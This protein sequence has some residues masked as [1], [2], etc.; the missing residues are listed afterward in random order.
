MEKQP[1]MQVITQS[2]PAQMVSNPQ[3]ESRFQHLYAIAN[4]I[5]DD[6]TAHAFYETE[7]V[8]F[9]K[10]IND[11]PGLQSCTKLSL[12]GVFLDI[13]LNGLSIDPMMKH[14]YIEPYNVNVGTKNEPRYEKRAKLDISGYG[15]LLLRQ[16]HGQVKYVDNAVIVYEG[17]EFRYGTKNG[18]TIVEHIATIPR[19]SNNMIACYLKITRP[20][21]SI[22]YKVLTYEELMSIKEC[23]KMPNSPAW[24][25]S[26]AGMFRTKT[27]KH[28]FNN[29][30]KLKVGKFSN[31]VTQ[32][33]DETSIDD[34]YGIDVNYQLSQAPEQQQDAPVQN[35]NEGT[36]VTNDV[37]DELD[38]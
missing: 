31:L 14:A 25:K 18:Q 27:I 6:K 8:H 9:L 22:D 7:K 32:G 23:S 3:I 28:A 5:E 29:Y 26:I 35:V 21:D 36:P 1:L 37:A 20:D 16:R 4:G 13:A 24:T 2:T 38:F 30:P 15:E 17:D 19:K 33:D 11:T 34:G 10:L 12:Y